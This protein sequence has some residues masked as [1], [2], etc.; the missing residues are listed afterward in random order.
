MLF[1]ICGD[2]A[3]CLLLSYQDEGQKQVLVL[4]HCVP[5]LAHVKEN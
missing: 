1:I 2:I 3:V 4:A 5:Q